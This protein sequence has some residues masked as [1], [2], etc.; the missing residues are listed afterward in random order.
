MSYFRFDDGSISPLVFADGVWT[1]DHEYDGSCSSGGSYR[2]RLTGTYRLPQP[3]Q[4][5]ITLLTGH[6][7]VERSPGTACVS[8]DFDDKIQRTGD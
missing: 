5:P 2:E 8:F 1:Q 7:R 4:D 3:L 6:G